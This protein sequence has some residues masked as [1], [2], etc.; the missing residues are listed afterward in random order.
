MNPL[1]RIKKMIGAAGRRY[2]GRPFEIIRKSIYDTIHFCDETREIFRVYL[3]KKGKKGSDDEVV[4]KTYSEGPSRDG[5]SKQGIICM[6][7]GK[8]L[9]GGLTDRE[10]GLLTT[11]KEAKRRGLP[12]Y[13]YWCHPFDLTDYLQPATFDWR[14]SD[15]EISYSIKD[16]FPVVIQDHRRLSNRLR[17]L[18]GLFHRRKQTHVYS[19]SDNGRGEYRRLYGELFKPTDVVRREIMR[20]RY[21]LGQYWGFT[22]RFLELLGD[23][24]DHQ[25]IMLC[26]EDA[27]RLIDKCVNE[28]LILCENLPKGHKILVTSDSK[29][30]LETAKLADNRIYVVE[31]NIKNIDLTDEDIKDAWLKTFVDQH[32]LMNAEKVILMR[33]GKMYKSGFP[34]FAAEVGGAEF[35]YHEF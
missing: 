32:L 17:L 7:D 6:Y 30:F 31:G 25:K 11:Y 33:T 15:D 13:I 16:S 9:H 29:R 23:F 18:G 1:I 19:N 27:Q 14:I 26:N 8:I 20:H 4:F 21:F 35:I 10:R 22:F 2:G 12:F 5:L 3:K 34:R 24:V 28:M